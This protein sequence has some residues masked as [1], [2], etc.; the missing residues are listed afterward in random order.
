MHR[1][2]K[3]LRAS[4]I[5]GS[6]LLLGILAYAGTAT[7]NPQ[8]ASVHAVVQPLHGTEPVLTKFPDHQASI[9][10][11]TKVMTAMVVLD[12]GLPLDEWLTI[13]RRSDDP[14]KN[15]YSRIR[16]DSEAQ[17]GDLLR[18][19]LMSSENLAAYVL[20]QNHPG[21]REGFIAAM[22]AKAAE[23]GMTQTQFV[24]PSG[25]WPE[26]V[27]SARDL[28]TLVRA[29][30]A[31]PEL[32]EMS[33]QGRFRVQFRSPRYTLDYG[34]TNALVHNARWN[35]QLSKTGYLIESGRCLVMVAEIDQQPMILVLLDSLGSRTPLGDA[36]R[37]RRW[38]ENGE[39]GT[40]ADAARAYEQQRVQALGATH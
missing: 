26:N 4:L 40:V 1:L 2:F 29:A 21:G 33:T 5:L 24:D 32:R 12:S 27:S 20:A 37:I 23:L 25:L 36:G 10:S 17:R 13:T 18:I 38:L 31:Y 14:P 22:N 9:A 16:I 15:A 34:N 39:M 8:L 35:V 3:A 28:V 6:C 19:T 11:I 30:Y 7:A